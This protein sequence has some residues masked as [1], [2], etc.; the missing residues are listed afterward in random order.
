M[1][2]SAWLAVGLAVG[3]RGRRSAWERVLAVCFWPFFL[4]APVG[5]DPAAGSAGP[6]T[7]SAAPL[8]RLRAA[9]APGDPAHAVVDRLASALDR[10][11]ARLARLE[12]AAA[13]AGPV[14]GDEPALAEARLRS[15]DLLVQARDRER[16][17]L[18][19]ALAAVEEAATRLWLLRERGEPA[20]VEAL[21]RG[22]V[23]RLDAGVEVEG[24]G[25]RGEARAG[26]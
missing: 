12:V 5:P 2:L 15:R 4:V 24:L 14:P 7:A 1:L 11:G 10:Q 21:L 19:V 8:A 13:G 26:A 16:A 25:P 9:L 22:L 3:L 20:E 17:A 18:G 6:T 23:A